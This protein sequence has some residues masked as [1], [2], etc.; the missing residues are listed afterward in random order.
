M[1]AI[2]FA[3]LGVVERVV[4]KRRSMLVRRRL[5]DF[6]RVLI[7]DRTKIIRIIWLHKSKRIDIAV[8]GLV[9]FISARIIVVKGTARWKFHEWFKCMFSVDRFYP[10]IYRPRTYRDND[11]FEFVACS[12]WKISAEENSARGKFENTSSRQA[13]NA[14]RARNLLPRDGNHS[15]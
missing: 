15:A 10:S 3:H 14:R 8:S 9:C 1:S 4:S 2:A 5:S 6:V 7:E 12:Y 11:S 13:F